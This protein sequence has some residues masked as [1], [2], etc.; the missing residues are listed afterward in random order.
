MSG[1]SKLFHLRAFW[2]AVFTLAGIV[3]H[4][5]FGSDIIN[6]ETEG[7]FVATILALV[8]GSGLADAAETH[9]GTPD[10]SQN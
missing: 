8:G 4:E 2:T 10:G 1:I 6:S 5:V 9:K 3:L 7:V